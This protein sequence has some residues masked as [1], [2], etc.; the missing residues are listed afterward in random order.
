MVS[1]DVVRFVDKFNRAQVLSTSPGQNGWTVADTSAAGAPTYLC[2]TED[3]GAMDLALAATAEVENVCMFLND[4]LPFD[5]RLIQNCWFIAKF[6]TQA[7]A[8]TTLVMGLG[9][10]RN[11]TP[12]NVTVNAWFRVNGATSVSSVFVETDDNVTDNNVIATGK[13]LLTVFKKFEIDF[14]N[15]LGDVRFFID[16]DRVASGTKFD[17]SGVA[18]AQNVQPIVQIQKTGGTGVPAIRIAEFGIQYTD[19]YGA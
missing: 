19:A 13:S 17:M 15:G 11:D 9:S 8:V 14:S 1:R 5:I 7:D 18:A 12:D 6:S 16:G 10:A 2:V 4:V 3:G